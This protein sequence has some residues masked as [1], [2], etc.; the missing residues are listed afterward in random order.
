MAVT[1]VKDCFELLSMVTYADRLK[2]V[3]KKEFQI[4]F[5]EFAVL[6]HLSYRIE[7]EYYLK[8][9]INN[10]NYKQ[11]QVV[12]AVKNLS[13][14]GY[15]N[16]R[17]N[18]QDERTVLILVNDEQRKKIDELLNRVNETIKSTDIKPQ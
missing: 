2:S 5:E 1:R 9:I 10:L 6:I 18:E 15:F 8:D 12:K 13:Q 14:E 17:R 7:D 11:P 3:I 16:K 4:S